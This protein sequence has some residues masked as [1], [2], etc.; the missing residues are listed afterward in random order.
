MQAQAQAFEQPG[1]PT[2]FIFCQIKRLAA[3]SRQSFLL[4]SMTYRTFLTD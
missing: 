3:S 2:E 4:F 1:L